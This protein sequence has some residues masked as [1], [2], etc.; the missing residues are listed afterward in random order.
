MSKYVK[1]LIKDEFARRLDGVEDALLVNVIGLDANT[2]VNL[3]RHLRN[4]NIELMVVRNGLARRAV[5]G[6]PLAPA[7][8]GVDGSLAFCLGARRISFL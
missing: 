2:S 8:D 6:S 7:L 1:D 5:E 4:Q 3:R